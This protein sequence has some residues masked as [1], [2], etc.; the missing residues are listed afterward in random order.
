MAL[1][2]Y[3]ENL[4]E[5]IGNAWDEGAQYVMAVAPTGAGKTKVL[6]AILREKDRPAVAIAHR[7]ELVSQLALALNRE[8]V[9]HGIIAPQ[10][11]V[12]EIIKLQIDKHGKSYYLPRAPIRVAG[13]N[14]ISNR[15]TSDPWFSR[16][17]YVVVDEGHH[18][19]RNNIFGKAV[20]L[21]PTAKGLF[22][23]AHA[24]RADGRGLG[25]DADG[26]VDRLIVAPSA[27]AL[28][29]RGFLVD[30]RL[31]APP[32]DVDVSEVDIGST[33]D[34]NPTQLRAAMH[35]SSRI[36]G[37]VVREYIRFA[38]GKLGLTF[39]VDIESAEA[40][41]VA[42]NKAGVPAAIIT[43]NTTIT[44]RSRIMRRF[45]S[46]QLLQLISVDVLGEGTDIPAVDVISMARPTQSFQ[47]YAQQFGR[48]LR[49]SVDKYHDEQWGCYT[50]A[51]RKALINLSRKPH[52]IVLD[53]VSN[54]SRHGLPDVPRRYSL[55]RRERRARKEG[56]PLKLCDACL[57][58]YE[59]IH[60]SC[61]YCGT[62][63]VPKSRGTPEQ[64]EG[65]LAELDPAVLAHIRSE[66]E[67]IDGAPRI[68]QSLD[69][70]AAGALKRRHWERQEAQRD[71]RAAIALWAGYWKTRASSDSE[72]YRRFFYAFGRDIMTAQTLGAND[73][74]TLE[75]AIRAEIDS[76]HTSYSQIG[77]SGSTGSPAQAG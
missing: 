38:P 64:V 39:A 48:C 61:P 46:R 32:S 77:G 12:S 75:L 53:H 33:G 22:P 43:G 36:V 24:V 34:F 66:V 72:S 44:D 21:F 69:M 52:A 25:R 40:I 29:D 20:A 23:T 6:G 58:P 13:V 68:P 2:D 59:A 31:V 45:E 50:D 18:V 47:L 11:V 67:R 62:T 30:Y 9:A 42:F 57:Q 37:D 27:R 54:W 71:L 76:L 28:I 17:E 51:E 65:D 4:V 1:R 7:Q 19:L 70:P 73:A 5:D 41:E 49:V 16:V 35:K 15:D 56:I 63:P 60:P 10:Q 14:T 74:K 26:Y 55:E 3:Q 8:G